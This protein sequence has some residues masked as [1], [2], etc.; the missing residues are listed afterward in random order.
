MEQ[1]PRQGK[2]LRTRAPHQQSS[3]F[4]QHEW[5]VP[6]YLPSMVGGFTKKK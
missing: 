3:K 4:S 1:E 5:T 2:P 6:L